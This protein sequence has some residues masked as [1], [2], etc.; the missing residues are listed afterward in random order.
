MRRPERIPIIL[1]KLNTDENAKFTILNHWFGVEPGNQLSFD[2]PFN[3]IETMLTGWTEYF[4]IFSQDWQTHS[5]LRMSQVLIRLGIIPNF[6]GF[7]FMEEDD[8]IMIDCNLL[9]PRDIKFWGQN[10]N[11]NMERLPE[12]NWILIKDLSR[13]HIENILLDVLSGKMRVSEEYIEYFSEELKIRQ[14]CKS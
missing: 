2:S 8:N 13:D 14:N 10:Y 9:K 5:D 11:K 6:P 4:D 1:D 7:W 3:H 12:T